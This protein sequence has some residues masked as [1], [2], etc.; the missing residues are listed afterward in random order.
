MVLGISILRN[1]PIHI[2]IYIYIHNCTYIYI[3]I[4]IYPGGQLLGKVSL[5]EKDRTLPWATELCLFQRLTLEVPERYWTIM[6][7]HNASCD[8]MP[9]HGP[10]SYLFFRDLKML[11]IS[12][13]F[14][15][16]WS[17]HCCF[18]ILAAPMCCY[19]LHIV[20]LRKNLGCEG[21]GLKLLRVVWRWARPLNPFGSLKLC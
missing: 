4:Y 3:Y 16:L 13:W 10:I 12:Q 11:V 15:A 18:F 2:Y 17:A 6:M 19:V 5:L 14:D 8:G 21:E 20:F 1:S 9:Y 7:G